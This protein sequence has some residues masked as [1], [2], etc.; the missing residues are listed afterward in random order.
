MTDKTVSALNAILHLLGNVNHD[1]PGGP[2]DAV[3][4][5]GLLEDIRSIAFDAVTRAE[6][7][8]AMSFGTWRNQGKDEGKW[9]VLPGGGKIE[10]NSR[11]DGTFG[12]EAGQGTEAVAP[13]LEEAERRLWAFLVQA[14]LI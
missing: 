12:Y 5:G 14:G 6:H 2:N 8:D 13:S 9:C 4:R 10:A 7:P 1:R 11:D 3:H